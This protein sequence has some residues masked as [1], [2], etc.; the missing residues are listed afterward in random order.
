MA[1]HGNAAH[2]L[3][4]E[5]MDGLPKAFTLKGEP[6]T[7]YWKGNKGW[8]ASRKGT[9]GI[10]GPFKGSALARTWAEEPFLEKARARAAKT[11]ERKAARQ[12]AREEAQI[13]IWGS[14]LHPEERR[15]AKGQIWVMRHPKFP[16]HQILIMDVRKDSVVALIRSD[17]TPWKNCPHDVRSH[18]AILR[19][20]RFVSIES[21]PPK[22]R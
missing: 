17:D 9:K 21:R 20:Y 12:A 11:E 3:E 2:N 7:S 5:P 4:W 10:Q 13:K 15:L 6:G 19:L 14:Q 16:T 8:W 1:K 18:H 22:L